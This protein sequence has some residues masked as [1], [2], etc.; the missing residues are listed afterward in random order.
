MLKQELLDQIKLEL[1]STKADVSGE[2]FL[3]VV[4][5]V[6][7]KLNAKYVEIFIVDTIESLAVR[8]AGS[9]EIGKILIHK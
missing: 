9:G 7:I 5:I 6:A 2:R 4:N 3:N 1:T 8:R